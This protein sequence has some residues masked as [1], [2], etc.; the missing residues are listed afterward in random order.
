MS[1]SEWFVLSDK[2][3]GTVTFLVRDIFVDPS[4]QNST[5]GAVC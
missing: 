3:D 4:V 5:R 1:L 2:R